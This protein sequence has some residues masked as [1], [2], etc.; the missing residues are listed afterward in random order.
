VL[1][2]KSG[3]EQS[4]RAAPDQSYPLHT[5]AD[6][7]LKKGWENMEKPLSLICALILVLSFS[8]CTPSEPADPPPSTDASIEQT[9]ATQ[10]QSEPMVTP[11]AEDEYADLSHLPE[12]KR[13]F[14]QKLGFTPSSL[15]TAF[16]GDTFLSTA[17]RGV[18]S[19]YTGD[20]FGN[21]KKKEAIVVSL[22]DA[23]DRD[24]IQAN[25]FYYGNEGL[26]TEVLLSAPLD[27]GH[28][29]PPTLFIYR[30]GGKTYFCCQKYGGNEWGGG[31]FAHYGLIYTEIL[32]S[33]K[34]AAPVSLE[35]GHGA[36][37]HWY[38]A[39]SVGEELLSSSEDVYGDDGDY[40][41][42][43]SFDAINEKLNEIGLP[44][45]EGT[46]ENIYLIEVNE[47]TPGVTMLVSGSISWPEDGSF[48]D[49]TWT[50]EYIDHLK[51]D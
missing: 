11:A 29:A 17:H 20:L 8:A 25:Y 7:R 9:T 16:S 24:R 48:S 38:A 50:V 10:S 23:G 33:G 40:E 21:D 14:F 3:M 32:P 34:T 49:G 13:Q 39:V 27:Y 19:V 41:K 45:L 51:Y 6:S 35:Y 42:E 37:Q 15:R 43:V 28:Q 18:V 31:S 46:R 1:T 36:G 30:Y 44:V 47:K 12:A 22:L 4:S 2:L 26:A 5:F